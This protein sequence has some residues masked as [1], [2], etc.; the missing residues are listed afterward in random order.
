MSKLTSPLLVVAVLVFAA[1]S[2]E[3]IAETHVYEVVEETFT[4]NK[5]HANPY[6]DVDPWVTL[7]GPGGAY[8]VPAFWDGGDTFRVR[9]VAT[10]PGVWE[11]STGDRTGDSGLDGKNGSFRVVAWTE[12]EK[13]NNPNRRGFIRPSA[14]GH[15]LEYA[16][17]T[18]FFY[19]GDTWWC[20]L[21]RVYSWG[22]SKGESRISFQDALAL[23]KAQG[24]NGINIIACFPSD[25]IRGIW[26]QTVHGKKVA[27][28]GST[29][30]VISD[31][32]D[33][34]YTR[35][36][37]NYW[38]QA[39]RKWEHMW[40]NGFVPYIETVRRHEGLPRENDAEREAFTNYVR[41]LWARWG[42]YNMIFS[43]LHMDAGDSKV[44]NAW[45]PL[46]VA[47]HAELKDMPY[48]Q[49]KTIMCPGSSL[50][51]WYSLSPRIL[52]LNSVS[53]LGRDGKSI[54]WLHEMFF[55]DDPLPVF[56]IEPFYPGWKQ[57]PQRDM[58]DGQMGQFLMYGCVLNGGALTGHAWGDCYYGGVATRP[59]PPI[60]DGDPHRNG[61][62]RFT[63]ASMGKLRDFVR[64]SG[65]DYRVLVP[66]KESNL[67][68]PD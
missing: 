68:A 2:S 22:S 48:G 43:W 23:R 52:D 24:I 57:T 1:R 8:K 61:F 41:Y 7:T 33:V 3:V 11:W 47:A 38:Q 66:A 46:V 14:N 15:T 40:E 19:T 10:Q 6:I 36:N 67:A 59:K 37:P 55:L 4:A 53:N 18:P 65:H 30:F 16:D 49:P 9:L 34:D 56:N 20:A 63:A 45:R 29:P 21:T 58:N 32:G 54:G 12:A 42:C 13:A 31:K 39:D 28:N 17:G 60:T 5:T 44:M 25:T 62:N 50:Q 26:D 27:E 35:I 64:D 51:D